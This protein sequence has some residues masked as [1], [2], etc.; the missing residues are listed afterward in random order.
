MPN[1][2][3][4]TKHG[5]S[6]VMMEEDEEEQLDHDDIIAE[7]GYFLND[8]PFQKLEEEAAVED[9]LMDNLGDAIRDA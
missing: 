4:W 9:E 7:Y 6:R 3:C 8:T 2:I 1:Y 5:E